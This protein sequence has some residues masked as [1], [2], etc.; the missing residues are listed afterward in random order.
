MEYG[1][2]NLLIV[3]DQPNNLRLLAALLS[4][5]GYKVRK[6]LSGSA[7]L[8]SAQIQLPDL[9]LLDVS[10]PG[11]D[12]YE[13]CRAL[14]AGEATREIPVIFLSALDSATEKVKAFTI[15]G[16]DYITKPFHAEEILARV[17][18]QLMLQWQKQQLQQEIRERKRVEE[19]LR[20]AN[21]ELK[22]LANIDGLT[23]VANRRC[24]DETL[25][26]EWKRLRREHASLSLLLCDIDFFKRYNDHYGHLLGDDCLKQ[27]ARAI[28]QSTRRP[29]DLVARYGGEEFA[30]LLPNTTLEGAICVAGQIQATVASLK[31]P[32]AQSLISNVV[33][34]SIGIGCMA[35]Q[36][37]D[38]P[39]QLIV[40][41]DQ[42]LYSAK[43]KGRNTYC[44][45]DCQILRETDCIAN[46]V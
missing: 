2:Q 13:V 33:T 39:E 4:E 24:F 37:Q 10:M 28:A 12:G 27:I 3:D 19:E 41:A 44:V 26:Q 38:L 30:V 35:P 16:A 7:A 45:S 5:Q 17:Q 18:Q 46:C 11:M 1:T 6:A 32:H 20:Q 36:V 25:D 8:E 15:G 29:A 34:L 40:A 31:I 14:K 23:Q 21:Q 9:V 43:A 22:R 42:A